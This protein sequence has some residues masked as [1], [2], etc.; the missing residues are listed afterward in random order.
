[1]QHAV[2]SLLAVDAARIRQFDR[3]PAHGRSRALWAEDLGSHPR[4]ALC[5]LGLCLPGSFTTRAGQVMTML[6][7]LDCHQ[8]AGKVPPLVSGRWLQE[9]LQ[10]EGKGVGQRLA[11]LRQAEIAGRVLTWE[12]AEEFLRF[13]P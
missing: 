13:A 9:T 10:L 3:L 1:M 4:L 6:D 7:D 12:Q 11:A 5:F 8:I 2:R